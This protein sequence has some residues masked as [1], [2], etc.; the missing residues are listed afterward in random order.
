MRNLS[1]LIVGAGPTGL[2]MACELA[3]HGVSFR[4]IDKKPGP[5]QGS[6]ATWIQTRTLE[7]FNSIGII[8]QFIKTGHQCKAINFYEKGVQLSTILLNQIDSMY[9]FILM[10]PQNETERL[11]IKKLNEYNIVVERSSEL[12]DIKQS[13]KD[14]LSSIRKSNGDIEIVRSSWLIACDGANSTV[15]SISQI[16]FSGEELTEQFM[17]ADAQMDSHFPTNEI[18]VFFDKGSIFPERATLFSA[19]PYGK[20]QYRLSANLY[21]SHPRQ[22]YTEHE[23]KE[24]VNERTYENY[25]VNSVSWVSPFWIHGKIVN[26]MRDN[27]IFLAGDAAHIHSPAG[28]Q[29]MNTGI[30]DAYNL[31]WKLSLVIKKQATINI[32]DS[33]QIERYVVDKNIVNQTEYLTKMMIYNKSFFSKL[34][35]FSQKISKSPGFSKRIGNE[36]TQL[37]IKY[38]KSPIIDYK[39]RASKKLPRQGER[40][41]S[42]LINN[43][44]FSSIFNHPLHTIILFLGQNPSKSTLTKIITLYKR[45]NKKFM[46]KAKIFII[47][48]ERIAKKGFISDL[49]GILHERYHILKPIIYIVRPDNYVGYFSNKLNFKDIQKYLYTFILKQ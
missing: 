40:I 3:R 2:M 21:L 6:N 25:T 31:A 39:T 41:T 13:S 45:L 42:I 35:Q 34:K 20:K 37:N 38:K 11:L 24:V 4:I 19:F 10:V 18:N 7:I 29:G 44:N 30:Q 27:L 12:I 26:R 16:N 15:R 49:S 9:P 47:T 1:V 43:P 22:S 36:L 14:V 23:V 32:L 17:V 8:D 28:G 46:K 5:T 48:Q 33:Y